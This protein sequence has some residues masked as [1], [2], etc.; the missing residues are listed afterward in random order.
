MIG[1]LISG[2]FNLL[3]SRRAR[4]SAIP[5]IWNC[6]VYTLVAVLYGLMNLFYI[7]LIPDNISGLVLLL[8]G[9]HLLATFG[10]PFTMHSSFSRDTRYWRGL[11]Q[12]PIQSPL[13]MGSMSIP[14]LKV[15]MMI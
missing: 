14:L 11:F 12:V 4:A 9:L 13:G 1:I 7:E 6:V 3:N 2:N 10:L 5:F 15:I 8:A